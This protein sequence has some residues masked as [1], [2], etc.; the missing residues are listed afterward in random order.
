[1][2]I[3]ASICATWKCPT[4]SRSRIFAHELS[5]ASLSATPSSSANP[6]AFA[7]TRIAL[8]SSGMKPAAIS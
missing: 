1:M 6:F 7:T 4:A 2:G 3:G 5:R 8:S